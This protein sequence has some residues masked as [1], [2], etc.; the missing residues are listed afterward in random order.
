MT[1]AASVAP[2]RFTQTRTNRIKV[3]AGLIGLE[4]DDVPTDEQLAHLAWHVAA[5]EPSELRYL[6]RLESTAYLQQTCP[7]AHP[8]VPDDLD[9]ILPLPHPLDYEWRFDP[10]TRMVLAQRCEQLAGAHGPI[11]LLGTPTLAPALRGH[12]GEVLLLDANARLMMT[13]ASA[14]QLGTIQWAATDL[15]IF[16]APL[17]W[18]HRAAVVICDPPWYPEGFATFL[19]AAA[20]LVRPG[21]AVLVSVPDVLTRPTVAAELEDLRDLARQLRFTTDAV[22]PCAVRYRTPFFEYRALRAAGVGVIPLDWRAGTLWQLTSTDIAPPMPSGRRRASAACQMVAEITVDGVRLRILRDHPVLPGV[23]AFHP[24]VPGDTLPTVS[25]RHPARGSATLWTSGNT[26]LSCADP[27]LAG[28]LLR[29]LTDGN[30]NWLGQDRDR[31]ARNF[32]WR[33]HLPVCDV[34]DALGKITAV[35]ASEQDD[36]AAYREAAR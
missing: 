6:A 34:R 29:H 35:V 22:D 11:A 25:R 1:A 4:A 7:A 30:G 27:H 2:D 28:L 17:A 9:E 8:Q 10:Q 18:Q 26:V 15:A 14:C 31:L 24:V 20:L 36:L 19:C 21:G 3:A 12:A 13:L 23:L 33:Y 32:A 5:V 16:S